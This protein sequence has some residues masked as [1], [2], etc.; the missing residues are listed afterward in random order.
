MFKLK[1]PSDILPVAVLRMSSSKFNFSCIVEFNY[2][3]IATN[4]LVT[5][6][7]VV[8]NSIS[9]HHN[10]ILSFHSFTTQ[11]V[12]DLKLFLFVQL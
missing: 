6:R 7:S 2:L 12:T 3:I 10:S 9:Q 8:L 5:L 11:E 1:K 4:L